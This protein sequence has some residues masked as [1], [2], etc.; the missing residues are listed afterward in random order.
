MNKRVIILILLIIIA[1]ILGVILNKQKNIE[2]N[3]PIPEAIP[4]DNPAPVDNTPKEE[5][6]TVEVTEEMTEKIV[7][8]SYLNVLLQIQVFDSLYANYEPLLEAA[9]RIASMQGLIEVQTEGIYLEYVPRT[10][11][12]NI[13]CELS[14]INIEDPIKIDDFYYLYDEEGDYYYIVPIGVSW[15]YLDEVKSI[16]YTK[17]QD[18]Y[19]IKCSAKQG[20]DM[21]DDIITTY[22]DVEVRLKY[23]PNNKYVKYQLISISV[24]KSNMII[25]E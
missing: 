19:L 3:T 14:G 4:I 16:T 18:Q 17:S 10:T 1:V 20:G 24:G 7:E 5:D 23:K 9:M 11:I 15:I 13:I 6:K 25:P 12:H 2:D 8:E 21:D 22:P